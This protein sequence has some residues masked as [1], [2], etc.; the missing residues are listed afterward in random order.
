[1]YWFRWSDFLFVLVGRQSVSL[2][3]GSRSRRIHMFYLN[4]VCRVELVSNEIFPFGCHHFTKRLIIGNHTKSTS[5][6]TSCD[7]LWGHIHEASDRLSNGRHLWPPPDLHVLNYIYLS[8]CTSCFW[9]HPCSEVPKGCRARASTGKSKSETLLN[10]SL[11]SQR[12]GLRCA[13]RCRNL[14]GD[15]R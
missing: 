15:V 12:I 4:H 14:H 9:R 5:N 6:S 1:M 2:A 13:C 10:G 11:R 7:I 8:T 3:S